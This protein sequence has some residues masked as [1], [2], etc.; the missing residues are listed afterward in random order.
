MFL[1]QANAQNISVSTA[2]IKF[3]L[4]PG[5]VHSTTFEVKNTGTTQESINLSLGDWQLDADGNT[6]YFA[7]NT[8][9]N[10]CA[11]WMT[12]SPTFLEL[13]PNESQKV[14]VQMLVPD[15]GIS[16]RWAIIFVERALEQ[17]S[18]A[19][20]DRDL[21]FG[22]ETVTRL[23]IPV[24]QAP[25]KSGVYKGAVASLEEIKAGLKYKANLKNIGD[26]VIDGKVHLTFSNVETG[27]EIEAPIQKI[28]IL[29][30]S[31]RNYDFDIPK[32]KKGT[33]L[34]AVIFEYH[35]DEQLVGKQLQ[36]KIE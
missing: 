8:T 15:D 18:M 14:K 24:Y 21:R 25:R 30:N 3:N 6:N 26:K 13:A 10:S 16:T 34:M 20:A 4:E 29:P 31:S 1:L 11:N 32:L 17:T 22:I 19:S 23:G 27:E 7:P 2:Q 5:E 36:I 28:I 35:E 12:I 33:Y 9:E